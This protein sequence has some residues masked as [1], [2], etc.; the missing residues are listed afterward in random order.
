M[1]NRLHDYLLTIRQQVLSKSEAGQA[2]AYTLKNWTALG[3]SI[4][5]I[6]LPSIPMS[7]QRAFIRQRG[8][9]GAYRQQSNTKL[10]LKGSTTKRKPVYTET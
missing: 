5:L 3:A 4:P 6:Q 8:S 2:I 1:L 10:D 7:A 9:W